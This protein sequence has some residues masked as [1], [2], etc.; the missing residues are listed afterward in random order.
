MNNFY[1]YRF[2]DPSRSNEPF[3]VGLGQGRRWTRHFDRRDRHPMT[4]RMQL[5]K[6]I[7]VQ[8]TVEFICTAVDEE[9]AKLV[10]MEAISKY[11]RK[12][13]GRGSLLNLTDGGDGC[14]NPSLESR[15]KMSE[16]H[17]GVKLSDETRARMSEARKGKA[18]PRHVIEAMRIAN[19]GAKRSQESR[20][21]MRAAAIAA[22]ARKAG[23]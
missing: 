11:G 20:D 16:S 13:L 1:V 15:R 5:L 22:H 19:T 7:G 12:D 8:P 14:N 17:K 3:Y 6:K 23:R 9:L 21:K 18:R 2:R 10:E 4:H